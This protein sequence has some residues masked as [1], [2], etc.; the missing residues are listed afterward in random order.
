MQQP[1]KLDGEAVFEMAHDPAL[2]LAQRYQRPDRR[3][4]TTVRR[5]CRGAMN[6]GNRRLSIEAR[7]V[8]PANTRKVLGWPSVS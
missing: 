6:R 5:R 2:H 3:P 4:C 7:P 1:G 8:V